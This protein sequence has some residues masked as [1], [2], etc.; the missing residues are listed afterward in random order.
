ML[1]TLH[2]HCGESWQVNAL[3]ISVQRSDQVPDA[4]ERG[5]TD[6]QPWDYWLMTYGTSPFGTKFVGPYRGWE[7][8][9]Q[10]EAAR[11]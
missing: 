2:Q 4:R 8:K 10:W 11:A 5:L 9:S 1:L 7:L 6:S 3:V